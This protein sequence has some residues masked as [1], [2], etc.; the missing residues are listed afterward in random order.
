MPPKIVAEAIIDEDGF[1]D[2][3]DEGAAILTRSTEFT[4]AAITSRSGI[5]EVSK[6]SHDTSIHDGVHV[7]SL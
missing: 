2:S 7:T 4:E 5:S 3:D 1:L 6:L